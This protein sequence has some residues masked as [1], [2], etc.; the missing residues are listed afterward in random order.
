MRHEVAAEYL[1]PRFQRKAMHQALSDAAGRIALNGKAI[2]TLLP[3]S[4]SAAIAD[5]H[6]IDSKQP[7]FVPATRCRSKFVCKGRTPSYLLGQARVRWQLEKQSKLVFASI[8]GA[9]STLARAALAACP[10]SQWTALE[11]SNKILRMHAEETRLAVVER[12]R[13]VFELRAKPQRQNRKLRMSQRQKQ[14]VREGI[15]HIKHMLAGALSAC[16][17]KTIVAPLERVKMDCILQR[18][19]ISAAALALEIVKDEGVLGFW[20]GN[21]LNVLRTAPYKAV[22]FS[23]YDAYRKLLTKCY[24]SQASERGSSFLA[25]AMA[26]VTASLTCFPLDV[27]RTRILAAPHG[28]SLGPFALMRFIVKTEGFGSLYSGVLPALISVAPSGAVFYGTYD[29]LKERHFSRQETR[30]DTKDLGTLFTLL[31][32]GLAGVAAETAVYPLQML[33]RHLQI[34]SHL[35]SASIAKGALSAKHALKA[36]QSSRP[37]SLV[38]RSALR[39]RSA[40]AVIYSRHGLAGFYTGILPNVMQVLPNAALSF[41]AY[42]AFKRVLD[43]QD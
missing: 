24:G 38:S 35:D 30:G 33:Q 34:Q 42:E 12:A 28:S 8:G 5:L 2:C 23:S 16:V 26:G 10:N 18:R 1:C 17:S 22:N 6:D 13:S 9:G 39:L 29:F 32:G 36:A 20:R 11:G 3:D 41:Y 4:R 7:A 31:Y 19:G 27:V 21:L 40:A 37:A 15:N 43:A 14:I 25:G